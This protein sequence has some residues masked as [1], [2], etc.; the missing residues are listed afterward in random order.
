MKTSVPLSELPVYLHCSRYRI[1]ITLYYFDSRYAFQAAEKIFELIC[2][3]AG[4]SLL[5][6]MDPDSAFDL[7]LYF[8]FHIIFPRMFV[9]KKHL[10]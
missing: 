4:H 9:N 2:L 6:D 5:A 1:L 10:Q 7:M 3:A 8:E